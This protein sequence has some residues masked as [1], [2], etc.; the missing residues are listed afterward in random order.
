M[1][2]NWCN[3]LSMEGVK[4][5][6]YN[7]HTSVYDKRDDLILPI[8][9]CPWLSG[10]VYDASTLKSH[11]SYP[12]S[13]WPVPPVNDHIPTYSWDNYATHAPY[14]TNLRILDLHYF[15]GLK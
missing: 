6:G 5:I 7:L 13:G 3:V 14:G 12:V 9:N 2:K 15:K 11:S 10:N 4:V 8:F 1:V